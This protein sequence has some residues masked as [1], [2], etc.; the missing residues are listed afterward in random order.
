MQAIAVLLHCH[1]HRRR[2][3]RYPPTLFMQ[4]I[5]SVFDYILR[6]HKIAHNKVRNQNSRHIIRQTI[7]NYILFLRLLAKWQRR[8]Q[9]KKNPFSRKI[10]FFHCIRHPDK[11]CFCLSGLTSLLF[12]SNKSIYEYF[13]LLFRYAICEQNEYWTNRASLNGANRN[14]CGTILQ[15]F[16][17]FI[18]CFDTFRWHRDGKKCQTICVRERERDDFWWFL[19]ISL[20]LRCLP[21]WNGRCFGSL[22]FRRRTHTLKTKS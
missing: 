18:T 22:T 6:M 2:R 5:R 16:N 14:A 19:F 15:I 9:R 17:L 20:L 13:F 4:N 21:H 7:P 12:G 3:H 8:R 1:C 10:G 11:V